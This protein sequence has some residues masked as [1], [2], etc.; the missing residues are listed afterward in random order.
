MGV[1]DICLYLNKSFSGGPGGWFF[2]K[3]PLAA[4]GKEKDNVY[5]FEIRQ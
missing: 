4:G 2:K 3:A 5:T 1:A